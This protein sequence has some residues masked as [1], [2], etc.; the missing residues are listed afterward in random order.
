MIV[1]F[2]EWQC[3][4][5][6]TK[7]ACNTG[8]V[9]LLLVDHENSEPIAHCTINPEEDRKDN[10]SDVLIIK[11]YAE[12]E[13]ILGALVKEGL[14]TVCHDKVYRTG[15][16][17]CPCVYATDKLVSY[18]KEHGIDISHLLSPQRKTN[19][20]KITNSI[21]LAQEYDDKAKTL[22]NNTKS[23]IFDIARDLVTKT[24]PEL[25]AVITTSIAMSI[26]V[27]IVKAG[28]QVSLL[29]PDEVRAHLNNFT[30]VTMAAYIDDIDNLVNVINSA[31]TSLEQK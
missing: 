6:I 13:G 19:K 5:I 17:I 24:N 3:D 15:H 7:Y 22:I 30:E 28:M 1:T 4:L 11:D 31:L 16:V 21:K 9:A 14:V 29:T 27:E 20:E 23:G 18:A 26:A 2:K 10:F 25:T 8:Q 12:N